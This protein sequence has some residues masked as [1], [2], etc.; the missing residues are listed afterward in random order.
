MTS[1]YPVIGMN[2]KQQRIPVHVSLDVS[3]IVE[4]FGVGNMSVQ[5]SAAIVTATR[6]NYALL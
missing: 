1:P 3:D 4:T 2:F 5:W 6:G